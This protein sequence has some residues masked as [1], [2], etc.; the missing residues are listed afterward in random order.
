MSEKHQREI[1]GMEILHG[2]ACGRERVSIDGTMFQVMGIDVKRT[3]R[4]TEFGYID[5]SRASERVVYDVCTTASVNLHSVTPVDSP[6][7]FAD[8]TISGDVAFV[9]GLLKAV[10]VK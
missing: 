10:L 2:I 4:F 7:G 3:P 6:N 8:I 9:S 1:E 5:D